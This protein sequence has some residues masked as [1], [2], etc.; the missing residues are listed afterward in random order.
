MLSA[1]VLF[2][3]VGPADAFAACKPDARTLSYADGPT[4]DSVEMRGGSSNGHL[5]FHTADGKT[6]GGDGARVRISDDRVTA[7]YSSP[8]ATILVH[9]IPKIGLIVASAVVR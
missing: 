1:A 5:V 7:S 6:L 3:S 4:K 8:D 2:V 9:G